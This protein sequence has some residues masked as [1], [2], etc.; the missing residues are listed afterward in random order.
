MGR[1]ERAWRNPNRKIRGEQEEQRGVSV[2][3]RGVWM[4]AVPNGAGE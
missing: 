3:G 2:A 1:V 4:W